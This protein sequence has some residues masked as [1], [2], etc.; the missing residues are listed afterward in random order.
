M[1]REVLI[2]GAAMIS[3]LILV[4][5]TAAD[6]QTKTEFDALKQQLQA[7]QQKTEQLEKR[8]AAT[9]HRSA[10]ASSQK[11]IVESNLPTVQADENGFAIKSA[12]ERFSLR[13][14]GYIQADGRFFLERDRRDDLTDTFLL[15][16]VRPIIEGNVFKD[17][18][19]W[20]MPD[21]G[22]GKVVLQ[23][24]YIEYTHFAEAQLRVGKFREPVG[25]EML[26]S[27]SNLL[28]VERG[29]PT[30][31]VPI[32]DIGAQ[33]S[34]IFFKGVVSYQIGIFNGV[35]DGSSGDIDNNDDKDVAARL[36]LQPFKLT[37]IAALRGLGIGVAGTYGE[38]NGL[39][40]SYKTP[41]QET[42]FQYN[43]NVAADGDRY[44]VVPQLYYSW[45]PL[46][47]LGEYALSNQELSNPT[48]SNARVENYAWQ[49]EASYVLTGEQ[50]SY[51]GVKPGKNVGEGGWG[52]WEIA[53]R[54]G[55]LH[56]D[57]NAFRLGLAD[58]LVSARSEKSF[59][60][61]LNWYLNKNVR[62]MFDWEHTVFE[63]GA[64][65]GNRNHEDV[66]LSRIQL[67]L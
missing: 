36:W 22:E 48:V 50:A 64:P 12:D 54:Y 46:G 26:Q 18:H 21:F 5:P 40:P 49:V 6:A 51:K 17:F 35:R 20:I 55:E 10:P 43:S 30:N 28:F 9:E 38:E 19:Y 39:L 11:S 4:F 15:R 14:G 47:I 31:I 25:L 66:I 56:I 62:A 13:V 61:G 57:E 52:A 67:A 34:G 45:G 33:L 23:D 32:R 8:L 65:T 59:G 63:D 37:N 29:L 16:R 27:A 2:L 24:A 58:P 3:A 53:A 41:A 60:V 1:K 42:F 7:L 44:R